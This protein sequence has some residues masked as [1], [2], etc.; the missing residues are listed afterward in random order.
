VCTQSA[1]MS[2]NTI[3]LLAVFAVGCAAGMHLDSRAQ[4]QAFPAPSKVQK[5]QQ[6]CRV[7]SDLNAAQTWTRTQGEAGWELV[8]GSVTGTTPLNRVAMTCFKRPVD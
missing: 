4:A 7:D 3:L 1:R 8:S 5:W 2:R 6:Y